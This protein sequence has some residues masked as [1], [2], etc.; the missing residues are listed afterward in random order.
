MNE[1]G[2][3][4]VI[5]KWTSQG[6]WADLKTVYKHDADFAHSVGKKKGFFFLSSW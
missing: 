3:R 6:Q 5:D 1:N 2:N 4:Y